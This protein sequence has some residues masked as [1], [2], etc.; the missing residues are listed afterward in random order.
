[1]SLLAGRLRG[2]G[3]SFTE[4]VSSGVPLVKTYCLPYLHS[5]RSESPAARPVVFGSTEKV[6]SS[7]A[8][9]SLD[10]DPGLQTLAHAIH[11]A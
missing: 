11:M 1:M 8:F 9:C 10:G 2:I 7:R 3:T 5:S 6:E 4:S